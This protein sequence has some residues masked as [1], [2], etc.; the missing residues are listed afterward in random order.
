MGEIQTSKQ[1]V[2]IRG[3]GFLSGVMKTSSI[4]CGVGCT[5]LN[6]LKSIELCVLYGG[7]LRYVNYISAELLKIT[8]EIGCGVYGNYVYPLHI[9]FVIPE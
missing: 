6:T 5:N 1:K 2:L 3:T 9:F 4:D 7:T 8:E